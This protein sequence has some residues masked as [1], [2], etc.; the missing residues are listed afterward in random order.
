MVARSSVVRDWSIGL[1]KRPTIPLPIR[2][3]SLGSCLKCRLRFCD[4]ARCL[5]FVPISVTVSLQRFEVLWLDLV[6]RYRLWSVGYKST[7]VS[8]L[9][10]SRLGARVNRVRKPCS[11]EMPSLATTGR[12]AV[13]P[14]A[15]L[16][17]SFFCGEVARTNAVRRS[18]AALR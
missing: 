10:W 7:T 12:C 5:P 18:L 3:H 8:L 9:R 17:K 2:G 4:E 6:P 1:S 14:A 15:V 11:T 13:C 16:W